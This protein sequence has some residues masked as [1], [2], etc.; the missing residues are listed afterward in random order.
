[1]RKDFSEDEDAWEVNQRN[2]RRRESYL[3]AGNKTENNKMREFDK[4][5]RK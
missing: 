4:H 5:N 3:R 1:L 2:E